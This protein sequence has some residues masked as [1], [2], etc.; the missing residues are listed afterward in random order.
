MMAYGRCGGCCAPLFACIRIRDRAHL[1]GALRGTP[2]LDDHTHQTPPQTNTR[3][4]PPPHAQ[5]HRYPPLVFPQL[6]AGADN[7]MV[8]RL[9][10]AVNEAAANLP[11]WES[12]T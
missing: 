12:K 1:H 3:P 4:R 7:D 8:R 10:G 11:D 2:R 9:V 5:I 6:P